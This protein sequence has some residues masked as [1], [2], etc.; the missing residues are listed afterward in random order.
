MIGDLDSVK[1][2]T[3]EHY[4]KQGVRI[5]YDGDQYSTDF[6]KCL[7]HIR[8]LAEGLSNGDSGVNGASAKMDIMAFGGLGGR[9]DQAFSVLHHLFAAV[10]HPD[11]LQGSISL[12][13]RESLSVIL[14]KGRSRIICGPRDP[15]EERLFDENVGIIPVLGKA[16]ILTKG[17]EWDVEDWETEIGGQVSTSNHLKKEEI[18]IDT[19]ERVLFTLE[20][21][22][23]FSAR[24]SA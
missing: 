10:R 24:A 22:E 19:S 12:V 18:E 14:D 5:I 7:K 11:W 15:V 4:R 16:V 23:R 1:Q 6:T 20:F 13:G 2:S 17:L 3:L 9:V 21:A 8:K